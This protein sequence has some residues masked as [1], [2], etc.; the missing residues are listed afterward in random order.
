[1]WKRISHDFPRKQLAASIAQPLH[2]RQLL[3]ACAAVQPLF[4]WSL[5]F[6]KHGHGPKVTGRAQLWAGSAWRGTPKQWAAGELE[7]TWTSWQLGSTAAPLWLWR[8]WSSTSGQ[9]HKGVMEEGTEILLYI[10]SKA[11]MFPSPLQHCLAP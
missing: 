5:A 1:M 11:V 6:P 8:G 9:G 7:G 4:C 2:Q 3:K 10:P